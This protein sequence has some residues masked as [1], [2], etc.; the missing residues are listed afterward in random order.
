MSKDAVLHEGRKDVEEK[1]GALSAAGVTTTNSYSA[2]HKH[3]LP[4]ARGTNIS[5]HIIYIINISN[6]IIMCQKKKAKKFVSFL[7]DLKTQSEG[8]REELI[9]V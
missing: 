5:F 7:T 2:N 8:G 9:T 3:H 1:H 6:L 4:T